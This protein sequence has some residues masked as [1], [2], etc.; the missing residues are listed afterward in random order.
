MKPCG[1]RSAAKRRIGWVVDAS[2]LDKMREW[3]AVTDPVVLPDAPHHEMLLVITGVIGG[4]IFSLALDIFG[5]LPQDG[6]ENSA[7]LYLR[8]CGRVWNEAHQACM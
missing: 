6:I 2:R 4:D 1:L 8:N 7:S 3:I 5:S